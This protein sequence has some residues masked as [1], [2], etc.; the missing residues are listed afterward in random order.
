M[1]EIYSVCVSLLLQKNH[2]FVVTYSILYLRAGWTNRKP[3]GTLHDPTW[4]Q[5]KH[6][7]KV[8]GTVPANE[9]CCF[10]GHSHKPHNI[11][12]YCDL[13]LARTPGPV[14]KKTLKKKEAT[15]V[16]MKPFAHKS[17]L[18]IRQR[19]LW[20]VTLYPLDARVELFC[21]GVPK[22][23]K[24]AQ[25]RKRCAGEPR[26]IQGHLAIGMNKRSF[27]NWFC[28]SHSSK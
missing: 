18:T 22:P 5:G 3:T 4:F 11:F 21:V 15:V 19:S 17:N 1:F 20:F 13:R 23:F 6:P 14:W 9:P 8:L 2:G 24:W 25:R 28:G 7:A 26:C 12:K 16:M 27:Q 10:F